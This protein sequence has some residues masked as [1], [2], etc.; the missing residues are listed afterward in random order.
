L[1]SFREKGILDATKSFNNRKHRKCLIVVIPKFKLFEGWQ[2][3]EIRQV[4]NV[5]LV[6]SE[7]TTFQFLVANFL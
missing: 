3:I 7:P 4:K 1:K 6:L 5:F 2:R